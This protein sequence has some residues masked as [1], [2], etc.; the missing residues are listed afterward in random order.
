MLSRTSPARL[1]TPYGLAVGAVLAGFIALMAAKYLT[2][3][4][5]TESFLATLETGFRLRMRVF[6]AVVRFTLGLEPYPNS[7]RRT[8]AQQAVLHKQDKRNPAPNIERPDVHMLGIALDL[9]FMKDGKLVLLK[10]SG[11]A[12]WAPVVRIADLFS[13]TWGG[14][15]TGYPDNNH[16][17]GR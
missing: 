13:L 16:F 10:G 2:F 1:G 14:R 15:F 5:R 12:A 9:N 17:D 8:A 11:A 3:D 4:T 6:L 7:A